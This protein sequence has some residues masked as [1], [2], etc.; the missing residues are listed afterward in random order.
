[1]L[2]CFAYRRPTTSFV[3][4]LD[5]NCIEMLVTFFLVTLVVIFIVV[6]FAPCGAQ[7]ILLCCFIT[8]VLFVG[9]AML[10][11]RH[12]GLDELLDLT[13]KTHMT[14]QQLTGDQVSPGSSSN[15]NDD[16]VVVIHSN[17]FGPRPVQL[18]TAAED[19][20]AEDD[21]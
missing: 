8:W 19:G 10:Q 7:A 16:V 12:S 13:A 1:M 18:T 21:C 20:E 11:Y 9:F 14:E 3:R 2:G 15:S 4:W 6:P 17:T 5:G